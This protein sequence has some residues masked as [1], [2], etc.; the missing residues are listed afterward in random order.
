MNRELLIGLTVGLAVVIIVVCLIVTCLLVLKKQ[1]PMFVLPSAMSAGTKA[2]VISRFKE[3][4]GGL[5]HLIAVQAANDK[6][7]YD[8]F[9]YNKGPDGLQLTTHPFLTYYVQNLPNVGRDGHTILHHIVTR[10]E[11]LH[12]ITVFLPG[13]GETISYKGGPTKEAL[14]FGEHGSYYAHRGTSPWHNLSKFQLDAYGSTDK[15]NKTADMPLQLGARRPFGAWFKDMFTYEP[16][17]ELPFM[18]SFLMIASLRCTDIRDRPLRT[19]QKL[20]ACLNE[21]SNPE[22]GHYM[23]RALLH[24]TSPMPRIVWLLW[25]QGWDSAPDVARRVRQSWEDLNPG[26]EVRALDDT[27]LPKYINPPY[28]TGI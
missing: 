23:E 18:H 3:D 24:L 16:H 26:W 22:T 10:Y 2:V 4:I 6:Q 21:H 8:V 20:L 25:F 28:K 15:N 7:A 17:A 1:K 5:V 19:Y 12:N 14:A 11:D 9:I 27:T 13:S